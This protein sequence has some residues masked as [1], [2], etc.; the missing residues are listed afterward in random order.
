MSL[1]KAQLNK[2]SKEELINFTLKNTRGP[3][4]IHRGGLC[5]STILKKGMS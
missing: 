2:L 1:S 3:W 5:L 4:K